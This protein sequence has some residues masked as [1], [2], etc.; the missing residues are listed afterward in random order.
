MKVIL[1]QDVKGH[2]KKGQLV[3]ASDGF[4]KNYLLPRKLAILADAQAM[5]ELRG[6]EAAQSFHKAEEKAAAQ[7][8][9]DTLNGKTVEIVAKVGANGKLFGSITSKEVSEQI[10][11]SYHLTVDKKKISMSD[12][13]LAGQYTAE[14]KLYPGISASMNVVVSAQEK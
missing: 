14:I 5:S 6:K 2:G 9:A 3:E 7:K 12:I 8:A 11:K 4:A 10:Q 1:L 13:K